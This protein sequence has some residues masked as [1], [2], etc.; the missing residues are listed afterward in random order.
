[1][2]HCSNI[3]VVNKKSDIM[4]AVQEFAWN[5]ADREECGGEYQSILKIQDREFNSFEEAEKYLKQ[6]T[7]TL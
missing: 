5:C 1:M 2:G 3:L 6:F 7:V 4:P